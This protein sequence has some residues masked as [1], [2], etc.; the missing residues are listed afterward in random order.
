[1]FY[2][3]MVLNRA[4]EELTELYR[5]CADLSAKQELA[6]C[7]ALLQ[8]AIDLERS[9]RRNVSRG[10]GAGAGSAGSRPLN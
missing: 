5:T 6:E 8:H 10:Q 3:V 9:F 7:I 1:M 2:P 4:H